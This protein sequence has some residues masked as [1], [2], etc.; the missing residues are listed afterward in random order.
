[1][2]HH[3]NRVLVQVRGE[4]AFLTGKILLYFQDLKRGTNKM[5]LIRLW[6]VGPEDIFEIASNHSSDSDMNNRHKPRRSHGVHGLALPE[7]GI[8]HGYQ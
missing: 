8:Q 1:M 6:R 7:G 4:V 5:K 3:K 2:S